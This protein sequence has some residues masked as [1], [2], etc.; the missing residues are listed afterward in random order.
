MEEY[1]LEN[2]LRLI[3]KHTDSE[4]S[5]ICISLNAGAGVENEKFGVAHATEHMVIKEQKIELREK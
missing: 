3:Y 5:S 4:L 1:I 2:D